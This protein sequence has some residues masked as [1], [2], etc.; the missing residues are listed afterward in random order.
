VP[1]HPKWS[2][3]Q[4]GNHSCRI[5]MY[6]VL[7]DSALVCERCGYVVRNDTKQRAKEMDKENIGYSLYWSRGNKM[8]HITCQRTG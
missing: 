4:S 7:L 5:Y 8:H 6:K 3:N 1:P 2:L